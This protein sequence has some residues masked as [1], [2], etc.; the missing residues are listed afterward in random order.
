MDDSSIQYRIR[1]AQINGIN[2]NE[3]FS[4]GVKL[5]EAKKTPEHLTPE[6]AAKTKQLQK[7]FKEHTKKMKE[8]KEIARQAAMNHN[9]ARM[10]LLDHLRKD[11]EHAELQRQHYNKYGYSLLPGDKPGQHGTLD[12]KEPT[13]DYSAMMGEYDK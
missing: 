11:P 13:K 6:Y 1:L 5:N 8:A 4:D 10:A 2:L 12:H 7:A 3:A 9:D